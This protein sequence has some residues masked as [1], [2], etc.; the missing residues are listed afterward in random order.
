MS[1]TCIVDRGGSV[2]FAGAAYRAGRSWARRQVEVAIV[3]GSVEI[4]EI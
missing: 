4:S 1:V 3:A 2:S